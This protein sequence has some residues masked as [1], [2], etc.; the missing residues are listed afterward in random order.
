MD[1]SKRSLTLSIQMAR[2]CQE[3]AKE[4]SSREQIINLQI[5]YPPTGN[6]H[7]T[8]T[9]DTNKSIGIILLND[10]CTE[11]SPFPRAIFLFLIKAQTM[12]MLHMTMMKDGNIA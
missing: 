4:D 8:K 6:E 10:F 11:G 2:N 9:V 7:M 5:M 1:V 3:R 12:T